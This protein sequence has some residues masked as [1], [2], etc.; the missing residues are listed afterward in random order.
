MNDVDSKME[1]KLQFK[2]IMSFKVNMSD[3]AREAGV[4]QKSFS[5]CEIK[6]HSHFKKGERKLSQTCYAL[7]VHHILINGGTFIEII[8]YKEGAKYILK[9][10]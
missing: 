4:Q 8:K 5:S 7:S 6:Y 3:A 10:F 1:R 2:T 9:L